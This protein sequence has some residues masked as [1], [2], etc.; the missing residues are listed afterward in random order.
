MRSCTALPSHLSS[1][2]EPESNWPSAKARIAGARRRAAN[3]TLVTRP[4]AAR[5]E[6]M[7]EIMRAIGL[8]HL[9]VRPKKSVRLVDS[10]M[11]RPTAIFAVL[12]GHRVEFAHRLA[13][14][15]QRGEMGVCGSL[16]RLCTLLQLSYR[17]TKFR[18]S[19]I[20]FRR[21]PE[22]RGV[23]GS[24]TVLIGSHR[25]VFVEHL[26]QKAEQ[27]V[28]A[29]AD[30]RRAYEGFWSVDYHKGFVGAFPLS[31]WLTFEVRT[32]GARANG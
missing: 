7:L 4:M 30:S 26:S 19:G 27:N 20:K 31:S 1:I 32:V 21:V 16:P 29:N 8:S 15:L 18:F 9:G 24:F 25:E 6:W 10:R 2:S 28:G 17:G 13:L 14:R 22:N 11:L 3:Q 5:L 23:A 12:D